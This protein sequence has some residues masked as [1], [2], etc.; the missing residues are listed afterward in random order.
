MAEKR[1]VYKIQDLGGIGEVR[2]SDEVITKIAALAATE[3]DGVSSMAGSIKHEQ[4]SRMSMKALAKGIKVNIGEKTV[5][6][7]A[8]LNIDYDRNIVGISQTVQDK[9]KTTIEN[10]TGLKVS[11]VN[12]HIAGVEM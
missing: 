8:N 5:S 3:A 6:V 10:M 7:E 1:N 2:I 4:I 11:E 12:V 9:V